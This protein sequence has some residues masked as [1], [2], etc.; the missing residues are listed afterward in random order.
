MSPL[1]V[2]DRD[3]LD[4]D[5]VWADEFPSDP[6]LMASPE[7]DAKGLAAVQKVA[8]DRRERLASER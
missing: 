3:R 8:R 2:D 7:G 1:P 6:E 5:R 4:G